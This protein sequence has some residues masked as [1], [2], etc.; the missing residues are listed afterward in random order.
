M[1]TALDTRDVP[2]HIVLTGVSWSYY[3]Q[4]LEEIGNQPI[5]VAFLDGVMELMSPMPEHE[6]AKKAI[7]DLIATLAVECQ[8]PRKSFGSTTFRREE[9]SAGSEPDECFYF[10][11]ID[12]VKGMKRFDSLV[13]RPPDLWIEVDVLN[14]SV[15]REPI[16]ARLGV[17]EVWR[18]SDDRLTVRLLSTGG[19]YADSETSQ[20]LPFLPM[21]TFAQFIP[22]MI[23]GDETRVLLEFR[24]WVRSLAR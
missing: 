10:Q 1:A 20:A 8:I 7:G 5:R 18:Y 13:H 11:N 23:E 24:A 21:S 17:P 2:Q 6:G 15:P 16:Y 3:E 19:V 9:K 12:A 4:T 14:L 22:K